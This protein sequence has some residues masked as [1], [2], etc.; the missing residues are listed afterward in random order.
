MQA[1]VEETNVTLPTASRGV[2]WTPGS[3][4]TCVSTARWCEYAGWC[5]GWSGGRRFA[6]GSLS[7]HALMR[8]TGPLS[9]T[10]TS[11]AAAPDAAE[12]A[13]EVELIAAMQ[14]GS[15]SH[16]REMPCSKERS[17]DAVM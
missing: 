12:D 10:P 4:R 16:G 7:S 15:S 2:L 11:S 6:F 8:S 9:V 5:H 17:A 1:F 14:I 3:M 13:E